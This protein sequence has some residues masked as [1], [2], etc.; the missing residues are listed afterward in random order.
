MEA[1]RAFY[2]TLS[3][4]LAKAPTKDGLNKSILDFSDSPSPA[5]PGSAPPD[6]S[7]A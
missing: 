7:L 1:K 2:A 4:G 6:Q 5:S 3:Q